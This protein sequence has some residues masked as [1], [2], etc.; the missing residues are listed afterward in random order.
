MIS[1]EAGPEGFTLSAEGR[2]ILTHSRRSPCVEIGRSENLVR[3]SRGSFALRRRRSS[4]VQLKAFKVVEATGEYA[5]IDFDG[6][7][8]LAAR[9]KDGRLRLSF[10]RFDSS[11]NRFRLRL[12]A[13]PD[14]RI[15]GCGERFDRLD[16][17]LS[18]V[19][20]WVQER[21][22]G[23]GGDFAALL[24]R[25]FRKASR[26]ST[27]LP[28]PAFV[29]TKGYWCS[30]EGSAYAVIDFRRSHTTV[31]SW[32]VP[33]E[34]VMGFK[35]DAPSTVSDMAASLGRP[36]VPP[37]WSFEGA[38]LGVEGGRQ[39]LERKLSLVLDAGA[40]VSSVFV[41]DW[42]GK[43]ATGPGASGP[44]ARAARD[45]RWDRG[46]YP[47]LPGLIRSLRSRGI[48]FLGYINPFLDPAGELYAEASARGYCVKDGEGRDYLVDTSST[49][50]A[51][52]DLTRPEAFAWM[53]ALISRELLGIG[54]SGWMADSGEYLPADAV[55]ASGEDGAGAHNRWP[56]LWARLNR[57]AV[58]E[59]GLLGDALYFLRSGWMGSP[60]W[61]SMYWAGDQ[62]SSFSCDGGLAGLIPAAISLGLSGGGFWHSEVGGSVSYGWARRSPEGLARWAE[63]AAFTPFFRGR[64]GSR[65][66]SSAQFWSGPSS[67]LHFARMSEIFAALKPY[68]VAVANELS[69][70]GL[71]PIRHTWMHYEK[72]PAA[73]RLSA[74]YLYGRDLLV[75][76]ALAPRAALT[77]LYLPEDEW[78]HL[79]TSRAFRGGQVEVESPLGYPAVFYRANSPFAQLFDGLRRVARRI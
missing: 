30:I 70:G 50:A 44:G 60:R 39:E 65:P 48:R 74:Q 53:K 54:M 67:L 62:L 8:M 47:E 33:R 4:P 51:M 55:L 45:W 6:K 20:L 71:P 38:C 16:L 34:I 35:D 49:A 69:E 32:A 1:I 25:A 75:A 72:D 63:M 9:W 28:V 12:S 58:E 29:S 73:A 19:P 5:E 2:R 31:D 21:S 26:R 15:Y 57:E 40:K 59:A 46:L 56:L 37:Y 27:P 10:S 43:G 68:H 17:K 42:C 18:R 13:A 79:W 22:M 7:L 24:G 78:V 52:V 76:P 3:Q 66:S 11:I 36:S 23:R 61:A 77:A 41:P 64:E 14:E